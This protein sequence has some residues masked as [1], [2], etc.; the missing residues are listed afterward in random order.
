M[1]TTIHLN[2]A[3]LDNQFLQ[4]VKT[5]FKNRNLTVTI[6]ADEIDTT[7]HLLST[8]AN[9]SR[10]LQAAQH[11]SEGKNLVEVDLGQLKALLTNA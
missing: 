4:A 6:E 9:R 2:E 10:L 8:Q 1:T 7:E 3:E 11:A 5:L